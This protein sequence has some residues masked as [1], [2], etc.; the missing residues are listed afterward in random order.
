MSYWPERFPLDGLLVEPDGTRHVS[1][2]LTDDDFERLATIE[3]VKRIQ[4]LREVRDSDETFFETIYQQSPPASEG[5]E[6]TDLILDHC[7]DPTRTFGV[8]K[9]GETLY[10]GVD[11][12]RT[13]G[14]A[15]WLWAVDRETGVMTLV[16]EFFGSKLGIAGVKNKLILE[17]VRQYLP[18]AMVYEINRE[19]A[20]LEIEEVT[21]E[22]AAAGVE[23]VRHATHEHNRNRGE[24]SV[25]SMVFDM[26]D[27]LIRFPAATAAD[28]ERLIRVKQHFKNWDA[29][30]M[31]KAMGHRN[32]RHIGPDDLTMAGWVAWVYVKSTVLKKTQKGRVRVAGI[33]ENFR[34]RWSGRSAP[35]SERN[36]GPTRPPP[37]DLIALY[38][39]D[40]TE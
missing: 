32:N 1:K 18:R 3:G 19:S 17:P 26:R 20:V 25:A 5:G 6:F 14:A 28:R 34:R 11:P 38:Y 29:R 23:I 27:G 36:T 21:S 12:A 8:K 33:S 40:T 24:V 15:Y 35:H 31:S 37:T 7:D 16:D 39:G 2:E 13:G 10:L 22:L 30:E 4:G 9:P